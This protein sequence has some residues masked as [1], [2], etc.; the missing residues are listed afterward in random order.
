MRGRAASAG[1]TSR[2]DLR[3]FKLITFFV[4]LDKELGNVP[5]ALA[6]RPCLLD[7]WRIPG[8]SNHHQARDSPTSESISRASG[9]ARFSASARKHSREGRPALPVLGAGG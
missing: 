9:R 7:S 4:G 5:I 3:N 6:W 8:L 1:P 2:S